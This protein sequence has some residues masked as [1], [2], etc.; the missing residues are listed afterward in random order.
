MKLSVS[1]T[2]DGKPVTVKT[3]EGGEVVLQAQHY[4]EA[5]IML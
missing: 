2:G 1:A 3:V 4:M 5:N